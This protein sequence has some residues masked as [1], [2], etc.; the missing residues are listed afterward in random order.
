MVNVSVCLT[1]RN[2]QPVIPQ[3]LGSGSGEVG[4]SH[5]P[6]HSKFGTSLRQSLV[7]K[8]FGFVGFFWGGRCFCLFCFVSCINFFLALKSSLCEQLLGRVT[9]QFSALVEIAVLVWLLLMHMLFYQIFFLPGCWEDKWLT[10]LN[11]PHLVFRYGKRGSRKPAL[12]CAD[13]CQAARCFYFSRY[14]AVTS[15]WWTPVS[16]SLCWHLRCCW[17]GWRRDR[18]FWPQCLFITH[19]GQPEKNVAQYASKPWGWIENH[20]FLYRSKLDFN[21]KKLFL[22]WQDGLV[23]EG[24]CTNLG[25]SVQPPERPKGGRGETTPSHHAHTHNHNK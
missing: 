5:S 21:K 4:E 19:H 17:S 6:L 12:L 8:F 20:V 24:A 13:L 14:S 15:Y 10:D 22:G 3:L 16:V 7:W 9:V 23:G 1:F 18:I 11:H 2:T 25:T